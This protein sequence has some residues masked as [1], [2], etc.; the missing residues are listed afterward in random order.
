MTEPG[1]T[2]AKCG[3]SIMGTVWTRRTT[4]RGKPAKMAVNDP[5]EA[6]RSGFRGQPERPGAGG[7]LVDRVSPD[8]CCR[9][10]GGLQ[11][12]AG[13]PGRQLAQ[14]LAPDMTGDKLGLRYRRCPYRHSPGDQMNARSFRKAVGHSAPGRSGTEEAAL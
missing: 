10:G 9:T 1:T 8:I 14:I 11:A 7:R 13:T 6:K 2:G 5:G 12:A 3:L 4:D